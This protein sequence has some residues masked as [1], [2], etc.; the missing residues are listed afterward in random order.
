MDHAREAPVGAMTSSSATLAARVQDTPRGAYSLL[1]RRATILVVGCLV[2]LAGIAWFVTLQQAPGMAN[3]GS[4]ALVGARMSMSISA[5]LF[6]ATWLTMMVAMMFPSVAPMVLAHRMVTRHRGETAFSSSAFVA[7]YLSS[8]TVAGLVP[9]SVFLVFRAFAV[10]SLG[11]SGVAIGAGAAVAVAGAYQFT[12]WK[13]TCL[14][15]CRTPLG[16]IM[17]HDFRRGGRGAVLAGLSH[18]A[19]CLGCCWAL[20]TVLLVVGVMNLIWMAALA[21]LF[22]AEKSWSHGVALTRV[23][24]VTLLLLGAA[25]ALDP[26]LLHFISGVPV[27]HPSMDGHM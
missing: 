17:T 18:G 27:A 21:V 19:Y 22:L 8:W 16:F 25:I 3:M 14:R 9:L 13:S 12:R 1:E 10:G 5:P 15:A 20:M 6:L 23:V 26:A 4:L 24:G 2:A 11:E 7:G